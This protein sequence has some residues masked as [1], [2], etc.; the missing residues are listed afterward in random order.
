MVSETQ[1]GASPSGESQHR[2]PSPSMASDLFSSCTFYRLFQHSLLMT[3]SGGMACERMT[4]DPVPHLLCGKLSPRSEAKSRGIPY[5]E[6]KLMV[7]PQRVVLAEAQNAEK[8]KLRLRMYLFLRIN[9]WHFQ[10][11]RDPSTVNLFRRVCCWQ[12][13]IHQLAV[14][15]SGNR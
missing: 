14:L 10:D 9:C 3:A 2:L 6:L 13:D 1:S 11:Q 5:E 7:S 15:V 4:T 12:L 8:G